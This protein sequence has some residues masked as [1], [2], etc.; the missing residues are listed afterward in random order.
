M[1]RRHFRPE[2]LNRL[3]EMT[4]FDP[5][6]REQ[7]REVARLQAKEL[8]QRLK[9]RSIELEFTDRALD[10]AVA[11]SFDVNYGAR[12]LRRWLEHAV[13][14]PLSRMIISG[15]L[16]EDSKVVVNAGAEGL[17]FGVTHDAAAAA[18]RA[19]A[20]HSNLKRIR[21][22]GDYFGSEHEDEEMD[23]EDAM[24]DE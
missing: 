21:L 23:G 13:V 14:T 12:P 1:V 19:A 18:A 15:E 20:R 10:F 2:F 22:A 7:L 5:L 4:V 9:E 16:V 3:D 11:A 6:A 17:S 24:L 8:N